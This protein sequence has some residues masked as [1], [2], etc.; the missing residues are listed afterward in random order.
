MAGIV[1]KVYE[2]ITCGSASDFIGLGV[3]DKSAD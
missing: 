2:E 1:R 3:E